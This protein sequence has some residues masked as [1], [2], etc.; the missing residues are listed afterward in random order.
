MRPGAASYA[1]M[2]TATC[3]CER[4][5]GSRF[6]GRSQGTAIGTTNYT[7]FATMRLFLILVT[8]GVLLSGCGTKGPLYLPKPTTSSKQPG[9]VV[10]PPP[11]GP[12]RPTPAETTPEP[13]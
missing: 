11:A 7:P 9:T 4:M 5:I 13:K 3:W 12:E 2:A 6:A 10:A 1:A 8:T